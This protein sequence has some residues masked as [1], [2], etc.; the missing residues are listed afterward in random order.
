MANF[1]APWRLIPGLPNEAQQAIRRDFDE[2]SRILANI[3]GTI[4]ELD[5]I[6]DSSLGASSPSTFQFKT[7]ADA[8]TALPTTAFKTWT[9]GLRSPGAVAVL[10]T[11]AITGGSQT[12]YHV[13]GLGGQN[14]AS[15]A[16]EWDHNGFSV[17]NGRWLL[18]NLKINSGNKATFF[19]S[20]GTAFVEARHCYFD[21]TL[22]ALGVAPGGVNITPSN[23][24]DVLDIFDSTLLDCVCNAAE[25]RLY[26]TTVV[27]NAVTNLNQSSGDFEMHGGGF[28]ATGTGKAVNFAHPSVALMGINIGTN[29]ISGPSKTFTMNFNGGG[30][31]RVYV[32]LAEAG[33]MTSPAAVSVAFSGGIEDFYWIGTVNNITVP[34]N[35]QS[36]FQGRIRGTT[37]TITGPGVAEI[38]ADHPVTLAGNQLVASVTAIG[39]TA[40]TGIT[41]SGSGCTVNG[42]VNH[43][44]PAGG[45]GVTVSGTKNIVNVANATA[46]ATASTN[47]GGGTNL[48]VTT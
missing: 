27:L 33:G 39:D 19:V 20:A 1:Q 31:S 34:A 13:I 29:K 26:N 9:I 14:E 22:G 17:T 18:E 48:I 36:F 15:V 37:A 35:T 44:G 25:N 21:G 3:G 32:V 7:M 4:T 10:E 12:N 45:I 6:V 47:P 2:I 30:T 23:N 38:N 46:F 5:A 42:A 8:V 16:A 24:G 41:V 43:T 40:E 11:A 28:S